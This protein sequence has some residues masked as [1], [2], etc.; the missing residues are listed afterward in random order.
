M[1]Q[2]NVAFASIIAPLFL[3]LVALADR[4]TEPGRVMV[5]G[6]VSYFGL[7]LGGP[8]LIVLRA[9]A[10]AASWVAP[11]IGSL[12]G[13][14]TWVI[15]V[16]L[17]KAVAPANR[18]LILSKADLMSLMWAALFGAVTAIIFKLMAGQRDYPVK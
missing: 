4:P 11:A 2:R 18:G 8:I 15:A 16:T 1:K 12:A 13:I 7:A 6:M 3:P 14:A 10:R 9:Q 17:L 5:A